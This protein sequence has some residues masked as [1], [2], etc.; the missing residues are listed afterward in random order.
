MA[1]TPEERLAELG[2]ELPPPPK[3]AAAYLPWRRIGDTIFTAGQ[4]PVEGGAVRYSGLVGDKLTTDEGAE[5]A[6]LCARNV[7]AVAADA[8]GGLSRL[9][10]IKLT[11]FVASAPG[12]TEQHVV[13]NGASELI[14]KVLGDNGA[15]AR[16]A[17]GVAS[18]PL[19]AAVEVEGIFEVLA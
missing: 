10:A 14:A 15:H 8:A 5:A 2:I 18:L 1:G 17:V 12:F 7:L 16:S 9:R 4:V 6:E 3:P 11:V 19:N 13:A